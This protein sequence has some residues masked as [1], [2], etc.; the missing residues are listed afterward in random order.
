LSIIINVAGENL[1]KKI[2]III[3]SGAGG[4]FLPKCLYSLREQCVEEGAECIV[5]DRL[6]GETADRINR[7]YPYVRLIQVDQNIRASI[8]ELRA[9]GVTE[10]TGDIVAIIE[11]HCQVKPGWLASIM[12]NFQDSDAA[13]GGPILDLEYARTR[14]WVVYFSEYHNYLPPW[15]DG[16]RYLLNG[17]NIA[18]SRT[19]LLKHQNVLNSG[20]W[21]V[22]LHPLLIDEGKFRA[23]NA[24]G[25]FHT[26]PFDY[27]YYLHQRY[28]LSRVWGGSQ[29]QKVSMA[30]RLIYLV[31]APIL[32]F[33]LIFRINSRVIRS[34]RLF[35]KFLLALPLL[36]PVAIAYVFGEWMGYLAGVGDALERVE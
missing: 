16:E 9:R 18:Y 31:V 27:G 14:D 33:L 28:L 3:A 6:G 36:F 32:P 24:M 22:V 5:V 1:N 11:E 29:R 4:D 34:S 7:D 8:P 12:N 10:A 17:A 35:G 30:K 15:T 25:V 23:V 21:E 19:Y 2:S 13:I 20:Y 26:G